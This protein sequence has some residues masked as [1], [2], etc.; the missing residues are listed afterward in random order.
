VVVAPGGGNASPEPAL[1][2]VSYAERSPNMGQ[3]E[4]AC[5]NSIKGEVLAVVLRPVKGAPFFVIADATQALP[6]TSASTRLLA[7]NLR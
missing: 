5:R 7:R 3:A 6:R 1:R 4:R 2:L